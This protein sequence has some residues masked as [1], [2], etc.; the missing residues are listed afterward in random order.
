MISYELALKLKEAGFPQTYQ[1]S[2]PLM[3][4]SYYDKTQELHLLHEDNDTNWWI[5]N[6]YGETA[7]I[8]VESVQKE[9]T[10]CPT[11]SEL[12][13]ACGDDF[14]KL[15]KLDVQWG[16]RTVNSMCLDSSPEE[17]VANLYLAIHKPEN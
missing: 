11:L 15:E 5:G 9:W 12:I 1:K 13:E 10:K 2:T 17:A 16:A 14:H 4:W 8:S 3:D 7:N 6:D